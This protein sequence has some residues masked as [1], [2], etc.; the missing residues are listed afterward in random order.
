MAH[1]YL[2]FLSFLLSLSLSLYLNFSSL[3]HSPYSPCQCTHLIHS[4]S[5][6]S[7]RF[8]HHTLPTIAPVG[9]SNI[10]PSSNFLSFSVLCPSSA[11]S[12]SPSCEF[13]RIVPNKNRS[14]QAQK[15]S[16]PVRSEAIT[17]ACLHFVF[18]SSQLTKKQKHIKKLPPAHTHHVNGIASNL[19]TRQQVCLL[20]E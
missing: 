12:Q 7:L 2:G 14:P 6:L 13:V 20:T 5:I 8:H 9:H 18:I 3:Q 4:S 10:F 16:T 17:P 11:L 19:A 1:I 15:V